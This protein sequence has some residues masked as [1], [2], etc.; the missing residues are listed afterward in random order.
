[1][2]LAPVAATGKRP[3]PP[4]NSSRRK[5]SRVFLSWNVWLSREVWRAD[6][7]WLAA[8]GI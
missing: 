4:R 6:T 8:R 1:M 5:A 2:I 3:A 7:D